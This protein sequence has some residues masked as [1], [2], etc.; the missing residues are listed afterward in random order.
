MDSRRLLIIKKVVTLIQGMT[1]GSGYT[2]QPHK[3]Y[4]GRTGF[5]GKEETPY[6]TIVE[7]PENPA[8]AELSIHDNIDYHKVNLVIYGYIDSDHDDDPTTPAYEFLAEL[9]RCLRFGQQ[10]RL[11]GD[12]VGFTPTPGYTWQDEKTQVT[13][14]SISVAV[15]FEENLDDPYQTLL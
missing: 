10:S 13:Y 1:L 6:V 12:V 15:E 3:V 5:T 2:I 4:L 7:S 11:G 9:R 8:T 14:C